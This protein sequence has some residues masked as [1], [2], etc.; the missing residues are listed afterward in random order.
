MEARGRAAIFGELAACDG[1]ET[2]ALG[3]FRMTWGTAGT[4]KTVRQLL[5]RALR[6]TGVDKGMVSFCPH[7]GHQTE[8]FSAIAAL[9]Y[10][11]R[12]PR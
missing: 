5:H 10:T 12:R 4:A 7:A 11:E 3:G 6:P 8:R 9:L 2:G 1:A